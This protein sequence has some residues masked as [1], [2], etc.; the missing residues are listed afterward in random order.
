MERFSKSIFSRTQMEGCP[1][2][3]TV[4]VPGDDGR[5]MASADPSSDS[6]KGTSLTTPSGR[7]GSREETVYQGEFRK[8]CRQLSI[9]FSV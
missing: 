5:S 4:I 9:S 8:R 1:R 2:D 7:P 3:L 6:G